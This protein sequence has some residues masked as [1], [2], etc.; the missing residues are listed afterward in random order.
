[1]DRLSMLQQ[2]ART[3]P[4]DPFVHYGLAME[5][6]KQGRTD[7]ARVTFEHLVEHHP[8]YVPTYL[9]YGNFLRE[10]GLESDAAQIFD[11]G[12]AAAQAAGD[13]HAASELHAAR[14]ELP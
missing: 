12:I 1:M 13:E 4:N 5:L 14:A 9:M 8:S 11:R 10:V 3:K 2:M 7:D 6:K